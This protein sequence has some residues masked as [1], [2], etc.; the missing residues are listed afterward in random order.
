MLI[1]IATEP[2]RH[3]FDYYQ[4]RAAAVLQGSVSGE[5]WSGLVLKLTVS[6]PAIRHS[7]L[8]LSSL[9]EYANVGNGDH[10]ASRRQGRLRFA[11]REYGKAMSAMQKWRPKDEND[12]GAIPLVVC[13]L[14]VCIEFLAAQE[15]AAQLHIGQGRKL[16]SA[17]PNTASSTS[18]TLDM[19]R[20]EL[21]PIYTRLCLASFLFGS[22][23]TSIPYHLKTSDPIPPE[24]LTVGEA[25]QRLYRILDETLELT[26]QDRSPIFSP[27]PDPAIV[28]RLRAR[29][30][31]LL[32]E[33]GRWHSAFTLV[34]IRSPVGLG[35]QQQQQQQ[36]LRFEAAKSLL[37]IYYH[38]SI[39]WTSTWFRPDETAYDS[40]TASFGSIISLASSLIHTRREMGTTDRFG[41]ESE[42]LGPLYWTAVKCRHPL[43]RRQAVKLLLEK[44]VRDR[45]ESLWGGGY[46]LSKI[47]TRVIEMEETTSEQHH[48]QQRWDWD[49]NMSFATTTTAAIMEERHIPITKYPGFPV[50]KP[51]RRLDISE[52]LDATCP[53]DPPDGIHVPFTGGSS[54]A[55]AEPTESELVSAPKLVLDPPYGILEHQR[56][57]NVII[58]QSQ[59]AGVWVTMFMQPGDGETEWR[60]VR[61]Y[62]KYMY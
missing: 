52:Q 60:A 22:R 18:P 51:D 40:Y 7:V 1:D 62:V 27:D 11:F 48:K 38:A 14:F 57:K 35:Q 61:E 54:P 17:I 53:S 32:S 6:E 34:S 39:V 41:F 46:R 49:E 45:R 2:E 24:F 13:L 58:G 50:I 30:Q 42:I 29:Q 56:P 28:K 31:H 9:H 4:S 44:E 33:L 23:P 5:F 55:T 12:P 36:K 25:T 20:H 59:A 19:V 3:A 47:A 37:L 43:L 8:A 21:V 15:T 16:L 10:D 26:T